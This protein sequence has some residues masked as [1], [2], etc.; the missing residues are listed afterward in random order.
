[1]KP[2]GRKKR[3]GSLLYV[4]PGF[5]PPQLDLKRHILSANVRQVQ[6]TTLRHV[7]V[8]VFN[9]GTESCGSDCKEIFREGYP[10]TFLYEG[11]T[12]SNI[13]EF[14]YVAVV[15]DDV[16]L[17]AD[18]DTDRII[19]NLDRHGLDIL[20]PMLSPQSRAPWRYMVQPADPSEEVIRAVSA[21]ELFCYVFSR[22]AYEKYHA[23]LDGQSAWLWGMEF[24]LH[25]QGF[26][27]G[28]LEAVSMTHHL[29]GGASV[30][31][32]PDPVREVLR[33]RQRLGSVCWSPPFKELRN[34][35]RWAFIMEEF[36]NVVGTLRYLPRS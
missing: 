23:L 10:G 18:F 28:M 34:P 9:Y 25:L 7:D 24:A 29:S 15:L 2:D 8:W 16:E 19:H 35:R 6:S 12:P 22:E 27:M 36:C 17:G 13:A 14:D 30:P 1:M 20:S 3:D 33:T 4:V 31:D 11:L 21:I 26:K 32:S 5:G